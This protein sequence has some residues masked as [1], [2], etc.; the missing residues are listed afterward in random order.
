MG[1][2]LLYIFILHEIVSCLRILN[3]CIIRDSFV[4]R[5][6]VHFMICQP[7]FFEIFPTKL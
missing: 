2:I 6:V 3:N 7:I 4:A 1:I 5:G